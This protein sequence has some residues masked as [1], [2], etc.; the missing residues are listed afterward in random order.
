VENIELNTMRA[1]IIENESDAR[2]LLSNIIKKYL[3]E[4]DL[5]GEANSA[6]GGI[7]LIRE[8][9]PDLVFLDID[10]GDGTG[11]DV[12]DATP[13][14]DFSVI[15]TTA[16][17]EYALK[18][19]RYNTLHYLLKPYSV[20][21]LKEAINKL[22]DSSKRPEEKANIENLV[23]NYFTD[24]SKKIA[25]NTSDGIWL[26]EQNEII[27]LESDGSY[28]YVFFKNREK[29]LISKPIGELEPRFS[30]VKFF[31]VHRSHLVNVDFIDKYVREDGGYV[32][33][34]N[35]DIVPVS[36]YKKEAF[37]LFLTGGD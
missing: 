18:A 37:M 36:R 35:K 16:Y 6:K 19:F 20:S 34:S 15:F 30:T 23:N 32:L 4:I 8:I 22:K 11:F 21:D 2:E 31:R 13:T 26:V 14:I 3:P 27:R 9:K 12:L 5:I 33:L 28:T 24:L 7:A 29:I 10:L 25:L 1:L 17:D